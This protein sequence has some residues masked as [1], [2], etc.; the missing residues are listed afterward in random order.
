ML[1]GQILSEQGKPLEFSTIEEIKGKIQAVSDKN[2]FFEIHN[3]CPG[4]YHFHIKHL[5]CEHLDLQLFIANDTFVTLRLPSVSHHLQSVTVM[6]QH[7]PFLSSQDKISG[8]KME[9]VQAGGIGQVLSQLPGVTLL[10]SGG[11]IEKPV[12]N[13][14]YGYRT[15]I[16]QNG[17][18]QE[19]QNWGQEHA[20]EI[21]PFTAKEATLVRG[22]RALVYGPEAIGGVILIQP[23]SLFNYRHKEVS[24][25]FQ[26]AYHS[27]GH[28]GLAALQMGG[29]MFTQTPLYWRVQGSAKQQGNLKS[30]DYYLDNTGRK[31]Q[32]L[33][34][35]LGMH[36]KRITAEV[37]YNLF[38]SS[39]G[40][41]SG[42]HIG[43]INDLKDRIAGLVPPPDKGFTY[44]I[45][46]PRQEVLHEVARTKLYY[47]WREHR[48]LKAVYARQ[49]NRRKEFDTHLGS[50]ENE[51]Q[52]DYRI[53]THTL[54]LSLES[55][56]KQNRSYQ[57]GLQGLQQAN[58]YQGR[59]FIPNFIHK[60]LGGFYYMQQEKNRWEWSLALRGDMRSLRSFYYVTRD[61]LAT[62]SLSFANFSGAFGAQ[63]TL[64]QQTLLHSNISR[65]W[66]PPMP[67]ELYSKGMHHGAAS[68]EEGNPNLQQEVS[69]KW[70]VGVQHR[71]KES[72]QWSLLSYLQRVDGFINLV[73][74]AEPIATIRGAFPYFFYEQTD[75]QF[76]GLQS[77]LKWELPKDWQ[78]F[79]KS[80]LLWA[81]DI[82]RQQFLPQIPPFSFLLQM[83]KK[84]KNNNIA[85]E[86]R[87]VMQQ[88]RYE[89]NSDLLGPPPSYF[90]LAAEWKGLFYLYNKEST[91][92]VRADNLLN[93]Q[94]RDYMDRFRY[95]SDRPGRNIQLGCR[96]SF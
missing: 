41:Y 12:I 83:E 73:P 39:F 36:K 89:A 90:L 85:M 75:A 5:I 92:F 86:G 20:P 95:F 55:E 80:E 45:D 47:K 67:N 29:R 19:G 50:N 7:G 30:P 15:L 72:L 4:S 60:G 46:R 13:G 16:V 42:A 53:G 32:N 26:T 37:S 62:P 44:N 24:G 65:M 35:A 70:E 79:Q 61:S 64:S 66:R 49:Y 25:K 59:F 69:Y 58:T 28:M 94:Y 56:G 77:L 17:V 34:W 81:R 88:F 52:F 23:A 82:T 63:Y 57:L 2:G 93:M 14:M 71:L 84:W 31:E 54:D 11:G 68:F 43:N 1:K 87:W 21:D 38:L 22:P 78:V 76:V 40:I 6:G 48:Y 9:Q 96:V 27:N 3:L 51:P 33:S 8:E 91:Y 10:S 74:S 18:R